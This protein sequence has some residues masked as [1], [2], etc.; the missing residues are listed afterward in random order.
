[1]KQTVLLFLQ[2]CLV[3]CLSYSFSV[4][5]NDISTAS[6]LQNRFR[7][8]HMVSK[9]TLVVQREYGSPPVVIVLPDGRKW[10]AHRHPENVKWH[11]GMTGDMI[12]ITKPQAGPWQLL[13]RIVD[14][15]TITKISELSI[16]VEPLPRELYVGERIKAVA[17]LKDNDLKVRLPGLDYLVEWSVAFKRL[18]EGDGK[19]NIIGNRRIVTYKDDGRL[20]DEKPD[21]G[22]FT[23]T[24]HLD[25]EPGKYL[26]DVNA[27]NEVFQRHYTNTIVL[28]PS[29]VT[30]SIIDSAINSA[31]RHIKINSNTAEIQIADTVIEYKI[32]G[33]N[34][35]NERFSVQGL[36]SSIEQIKIPSVE[37]YGNY[38]VSV[39]A[40]STTVGGREI[41]IKLPDI[42]FNHEPP[43]AP[44]KS[45]LELAQEEAQKLQQK[46]K[47]AKRTILTWVIGLVLL[48]TLLIATGIVVGR[49]L[50]VRKRALK[51]AEKMAEMKSGL[52]KESAPVENM[53]LNDIDLT[54][55]EDVER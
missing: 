13:G 17:Q 12:E 31:E 33:P 55:P 11:D 16:D 14:G 19:Q 18:A 49:K 43:P 7:I 51:T 53:S 48:F 52:T 40:A 41:L 4:K 34:N 39:M 36:K 38:I 47:S 32:M 8:D 30:T 21:D 27:H 2:A 15:S 20:L 24:F 37:E 54:M 5:A 35:L 44:A 50:K 26:F 23:S 3:S 46:E 10:Y 29:P 45:A 6:E 9:L 25:L 1:M 28:K 22:I 42:S